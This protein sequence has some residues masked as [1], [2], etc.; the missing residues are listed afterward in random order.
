MKLSEIKQIDMEKF[1]IQIGK[2][3]DLNTGLSKP[4]Q[5]ITITEDQFSLIEQFADI[6]KDKDLNTIY[7]LNE[8]EFTVVSKF[9]VD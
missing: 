6:K 1:E 9:F 3:I 5:V 7:K 2:C 8:C 4:K